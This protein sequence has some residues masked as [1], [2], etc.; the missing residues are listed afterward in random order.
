MMTRANRLADVLGGVAALDEERLRLGPYE[1]ARAAL[2]SVRGVGPYTAHTLL[3]RALGRP[4]AVPLEMPQFVNVAVG[5]YGDPPPAP[6]ELRERYGPWVGWWA[7]ACRTALSW[8]EQE[9]RARERAERRR[10]HA[11]G[12]GRR[13]AAPSPAAPEVTAAEPEVTA[14]EPEVAIAG[15]G[16]A[17]VAALSAVGP[18]VETVRPDVAAVG[19]G[20]EAVRPDV[21]AVAAVGLGVETVRADVAAGGTGGAGGATGDTG[22]AAVEALAAA[23]GVAPADFAALFASVAATAYPAG[24]MPVAGA[25]P[26]GLAPDPKSAT[27][28][29]GEPAGPAGGGEPAAPPGDAVTAADLSPVAGFTAADA[30]ALVTEAAI[31]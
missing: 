11:A 21:A 12:R 29:W 16:V 24:G 13:P 10:Q 2:L 25:A 28:G 7:Y 17:T 14:A 1:E 19:P 20:V 8:L 23:V 15:P 3:L 5:V 18:G 30:R 4:D 27:A 6:D 22:T 31:G 9:R 26:A